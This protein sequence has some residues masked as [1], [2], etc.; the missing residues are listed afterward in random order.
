MG[1]NLTAVIAALPKT[2]RDRIDKRYIEL[3]RE[4]ENLAVLREVA[5]KAQTEVAAALKITQPSVSK[6]EKQA[7]MLLST[8]RSYVHALGGDLEFV[9]RFPK[10][11]PLRLAGF[12]EVFGL[13]SRRAGAKHP[14]VR[15]AARRV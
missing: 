12:G 1:R 13:S 10:Q 2:R 4:V 14:P 11:E 6:V 8:L 5:G 7:D 3:Q 15:R 9:V